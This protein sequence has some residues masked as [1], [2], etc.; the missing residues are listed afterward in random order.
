MELNN[1]QSGQEFARAN[2]SMRIPAQLSQA[3]A[4]ETTEVK[5]ERSE[6]SLNTLDKRREESAQASLQVADIKIDEANSARL[7]QAVVEIEGFLKTQNRN[8]AFEIDDKSQRPIVTVKDS[9]SGDV[10]RQIPSEEVLKM[11][12]RIKELQEDVGSRVGVFVNSQA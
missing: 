1:M 5:S 2:V 7:Q 9:S 11:A 3:S 12:E 10:I 4:N 6:Q 8:L